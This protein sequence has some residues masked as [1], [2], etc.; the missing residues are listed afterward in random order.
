VWFQNRRAKFRKVQRQMMAATL[1]TPSTPSGLL[2]SG[3]PRPQLP[4]GFGQGFPGMPGLPGYPATSYPYYP[5][6]NPAMSA[7]EQNNS[8][9]VKKN[10][11]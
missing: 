10:P 4:S 11:N 5:L 7:S 2:T 1:N 3:P 8:K 9:L 6:G